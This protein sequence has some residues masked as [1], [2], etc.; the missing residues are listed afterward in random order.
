MAKQTTHQT[1]A[2]RRKILA[3]SR[4]LRGERCRH[5]RNAGHNYFLLEK[6]EAGIVLTGTE[7]NRSARARPTLKDAY[8]WS[9]MANC[10]C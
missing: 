1:Q 6:F 8:G 2:N 7:V 9:K 5:N 4:R 3:V 10:G